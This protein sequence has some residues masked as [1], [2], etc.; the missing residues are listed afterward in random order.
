MYHCGESYVG[1]YTKDGKRMDKK[2]TLTFSSGNQYVG[3]F[4]DGRFDGNGTIM[5]T[6]EQGAGQH[7]AKWEAGIALEGECIFQDGLSFDTEDWGF[8]TPEDRRLWK[9]KLTFVAPAM[10][11]RGAPEDVILPRYEDAE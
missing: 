11:T 8:C 7:R 1:E 2:G 4:N 6:K 9:E 3:D 5:F 10:P